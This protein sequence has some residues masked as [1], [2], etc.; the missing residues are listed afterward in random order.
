MSAMHD[1]QLQRRWTAALADLSAAIPH[2]GVRPTDPAFALEYVSMARARA[3]ALSG[4]PRLMVL[5]GPPGVGK[6]TIARTLKAN[7]LTY[8][9][10]ITDR[11]VR[12][13]EKQ[14]VDY[15]FVAPQAFA[16]LANAGNL[17]AAKETFGNHYAFLKRDLQ[18]I[19]SDAFTAS[20][21]LLAA[22]T[23]G[24]EQVPGLEAPHVFNLT[25]LPP[26]FDE[27]LRRLRQQQHDGHLNQEQ[28]ELRLS[29][30]LRY[31]EGSRAYFAAFPRSAYLIYDRLERILPLLHLLRRG[32]YDDIC[33]AVTDNG[34]PEY[35]VTRE[36]AHTFGIQHPVVV[37]YVFD[38]QGR[39]LLQQR[40]ST[41]QW[42]HSAAGHLG[43]GEEPRG[44]A[45]RE[46]WEELQIAGQLNVH[47]TCAPQGPRSSATNKHLFHCFSLVARGPF[48]PDPREVRDLR[49]T[50]LADLEIALIEDPSS[51]TSGLRATYPW[52][53]ERLNP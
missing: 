39:L 31:V 12:T 8:I 9:P 53:K 36:Y 32:A 33:C 34:Q 47:G 43:L 26:S 37:I 51:Y 16:Q 52:V 6:S 4:S 38:P 29:E 20:S 50:T 45:E 22:M 46:L 28:F 2:V 35:A 15:Q 49:F 27:W 7:G 1:T 11:P 17:F 3:L 10:R 23:D 30:G 18:D 19:T 44:G 14:G 21:G 24:R 13:T 25:I 40:A 42:D 48:S 41:G 5:H